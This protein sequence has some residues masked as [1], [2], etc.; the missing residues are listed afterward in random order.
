MF[1]VHVWRMRMLVTP[2]FVPMPMTM[3]DL[4]WGLMNV[5]MMPVTVVMCMLVLNGLVRVRVTVRLG[6]V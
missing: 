6:D 3:C 5:I 4:H 2:G 1:V